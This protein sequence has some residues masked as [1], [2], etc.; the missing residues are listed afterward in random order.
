MRLGSATP[1][2]A[3][4]G[5]PWPQDRER[6]MKLHAKPEEM[7]EIERFAKTL[8]QARLAAG[9][10]RTALAAQAGLSDCTIK[11]LEMQKIRP[12][13]NALSRLFF[14]TKLGLQI[15]DVPEFLRSAVSG[16]ITRPNFE[17]KKIAYLCRHC[18][19]LLLPC[20]EPSNYCTQTSYNPIPTEPSDDSANLAPTS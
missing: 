4:L 20:G 17:P 10:T 13:V 18:K 2:P 16:V 3:T 14:V 6:A 5:P 19:A 8:K 15:D 11:F 9:L 1:T 12:S 7:P